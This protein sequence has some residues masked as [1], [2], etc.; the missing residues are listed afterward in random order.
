MRNGLQKVWSSLSKLGKSSFNAIRNIQ[1][2]KASKTIGK[3]KFGDRVKSMHLGAKTKSVGSAAFKEIKNLHVQNP[4]KSVGMKLFIIFFVSILFFVLTVGMI[5]YNLSKN[6]IKNEVSQSSGQTITQAGQKLDFLFGTYTDLSLQMVLDKD[7]Q[8]WL[9]D[10][11]NTPEN[12]YEYISIVRQ[13]NDKLTRTLFAIK[14]VKGVHLYKMDGNAILV[15]G[16]GSKPQGSIINEDWFQKILGASGLPAWLP[17]KP[18]GYSNQNSTFAIGR[19]IKDASSGNDEGVLVIE[20]S[21]ESLMDELKKIDIGDDSD[22]SLITADNRT[23]A[24]SKLEDVDQSAHVMLSQEEMDMDSGSFIN[25][26]DQLVVHY[27]SEVSGWYLVG[28]IPVSTLVKEAASIFK[29][30][31]IVALIATIAAIVIGWLVARMIGRPLVNLRNLMSQGAQ[32]KLTVR[33]NYKSRDEIG[34]LGNSFDTMMANITALVQQTSESAKLVLNTAEE[35]THS[36]KMTATAAREIAIA[37]DE[38]SHGASGLATESERGNELT[39]HIGYQMKNVIT[40]NLDMGNSAADVQSSSERGTSYMTELSGKT[41]VTEEMIRSMVEKVDKLKDST[42]S[43]R[44]ILEVLNNMTKQTNILSLNATIEAARAGAAGKGFM[45]VADE[46]RKLADQSRQSIDIVGQI[47]E[48]IQVE[49]D[50]TVKVL[51]NATPIFQ[52][53][54]LSVKEANTIFHQVTSHMTGFIQQLSAVSDSISTLEQS[55][56]VLSDAMTNVS[57][58]AEESLATS[59]EVASLSSEQL[60]ISDA[61]VKLSDKLS[62]LSNSLKESLSKFEVE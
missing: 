30:T 55:Q 22:L 48:S 6:V 62:Q 19:V 13:I 12:T 16:N 25:S 52:E 17:A 31:L 50:E 54:I 5:S 61:L 59:E 26:L 53:Q 38:I 1:W 9:A 11:N 43:I 4:I 10:L 18:K 8:Q 58:V 2:G 23:V 27:K 20:I 42:R 57:A 41:N 44:K 45:V 3:G 24:A 46:I 47:T 34:Q 28:A 51:S 29:L 14:E 35:L 33:A 37:T 49:I 36:S 56:M 21:S 32:G 15:T 39:Q 40:A 7:L 60:G